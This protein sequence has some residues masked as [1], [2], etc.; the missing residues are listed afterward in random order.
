MPRATADEVKARD[1][2][3]KCFW[4]GGAWGDVDKVNE[5]FREGQEV[6]AE[7]RG[8]GQEQGWQEG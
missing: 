3:V 1:R 5:A 2:V 7:T 6:P 8:Q 4:G